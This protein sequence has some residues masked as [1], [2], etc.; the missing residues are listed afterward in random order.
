MQYYSFCRIID[1]MTEDVFFRE[2][3]TFKYTFGPNILFN[4]E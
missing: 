3:G 1:L 4:P 2:V